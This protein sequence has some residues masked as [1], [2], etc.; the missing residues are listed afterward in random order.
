MSII[1]SKVFL[2]FGLILATIVSIQAQ[3]SDAV[4]QTLRWNNTDLN[5]G[6]LTLGE[7]QVYNEAFPLSDA[8]FYSQ[9]Y[10]KAIITA[11]SLTVQASSIISIPDSLASQLSEAYIYNIDIVEIRQQYRLHLHLNPI[12]KISNN[13]AEIIT[14]F[15]INFQYDPIVSSSLRNPEATYQ[16][17]LASGDIYKI[18]INKTGLY[19]IDKT[20]LESQ[21][22]INVNNINPKK[23]KIYGNRGGRIP[24]ANSAYRVD[25]LKQLSIYITGES[26][27]KFD[28]GDYILFYGEGADMWSWDEAAQR[29]RFDKNIYDEYNYYFIKIDQEDGLRIKTAVQVSESPEFVISNY[30]MLQRWEEDKINLLGSFSGTEGTGKDWYGD[31]FNSVKEKK[32]NTS[33]DFTGL[34]R[35]SLIQVEMA[36]AARGSSASSVTLKIGD[37]SF[38]KSISSVNTINYE[39]VYAR[40][41]VLQEKFLTSQATPEVI[42]SY[43]MA[44]TDFTGWLD[45]I[46]I[47]NNRALTAPTAGQISFRNYRTQGYRTAAFEFTQAH[48]ATIWDVTD[49]FTPLL[50]P[51]TGK[52]FTFYPESQNKAF[53]AHQLDKGALEPVAMGKISPQNLHAMDNEDMIIVYHPNFKQEAERLADFRSKQSGLKILLASTDQIFN[54]FGGGKADPA[55]IRDMARLLLYRNPDFKYLLLFGDGSYDYKGIDKSI[56]AENFVPLYETDESLDPIYGFPSDDFFGLLGDNEGIGLVGGLDIYIGRIPIRSHEEAKNVVDKI[57]HYETNPATLGDWRIRTGYVCDD[58]DSNVHLRDTDEI[59]RTD[60][61]RHA[62]FTQQ[63]V[64]IDAYKQVS[65]SGEKR[66][67]DANKAINDQIFKGQISMTYLGHGGPL[68]WAQERI[69][70]IPD[71]DSWTNKD[72]LA[73]IVTATCSFGAYD[74]PAKLSPAEAAL[75]NP[76]GGAIGLM[77]TTRAVYTNTNKLLTDATHEQMLKKVN[78]QAPTLGYIMTEGKNKYHT[79]GSFRTNS[80]KFVLLGDPSVPLA[81]P[82]YQVITEKINGKDATGVI[83]TISALKKVVISG[84]VGDADNQILSDFNGTIYV[85]VYDKKSQLLTLS[86]DGRTSPVFPFTMY[87]NVIFKG[88]ATVTSG[89]WSISFW[90]PK[91]IDYSYGLGRIAYYAHDGSSRDAAGYFNNIPIGGSSKNLVIDNQPPQLT[92]YM[93][94][95]SFV[96]GGVTNANPIL[97]LNLSD[98]LGINVT[99]NAIGQ[100]IT[101][102]LDGDNSNIFILNDFYEAKKDDYTSGVVRFPLN[103]LSTGSHYIM[104]KAWDISGNSAE[105][106][107]DFVV[108]DQNDH[109]LSRVINYPNPFTTNTQFQFEHNLSNTELEIVVNIYTITGRLVKSIVQTKYSSSFRVN[110]IT[111]SGDDDF[112]ADLARGVYLY[113]IQIWSK[114][115]NIKKESKFE[116]LVK[117]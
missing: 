15:S 53:L 22:G 112:G 83:D 85:T 75:L 70:T 16:S 65:T 69:L 55:A 117:L 64:Y 63:K 44:S 73:L 40:R 8:F 10:S 96:S 20:F 1:K 3:Y 97:L 114:E 88:T 113:K 68:G 6:K 48:E 60:E 74:N 80:R 36:F 12:R 50:I 26:D 92:A 79:D 66:Y 93:N 71:I 47:I 90:T 89:N 110:D 33:F 58:E 72:N 109:A 2:I 9:P 108:T 99:G 57:I 62:L 42:L 24:E 91:N 95:E 101:A 103:K 23:I 35:D 30:D 49:P 98:D 107:I 11:S 77:T 94:D 116:K 37:K 105:T 61:N 78:G 104:A 106:R 111:W 45:Y 100:D 102:T 14:K 18:K 38:N 39:S 13:Q 25:D 34:I 81:L 19:K 28:A 41:I 7:N 115:L 4:Q 76:K 29:Y 46:Q 27:I 5:E 21:L 67:P 31:I 56:P 82:K 51:N 17:V 52:G 59:A 43:P 84:F 87:K 54:E 86:N 32:Y